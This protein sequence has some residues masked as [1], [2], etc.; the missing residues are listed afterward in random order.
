LKYY[1]KICFQ[2]DDTLTIL[3]LSDIHYEPTYLP[4]GNAECD[5]PMCCRNDQGLP[6]RP[7]AAAGYWGAYTCDTPWNVFDETMMQ[8]KKAHQVKTHAF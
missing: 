5:A 4:G 2:A 3:Q 1:S 8:I 7:E 6:P